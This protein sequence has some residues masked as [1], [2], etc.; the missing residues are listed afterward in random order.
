[1]HLPKVSIGLPV[2]NGEKHLRS[3]LDCILGQDFSDLEVI[4]SDNAS[5]D[6]TQAICQ[7]YAAKDGRIRYLRNEANI[8]ATANYNRVFKLANGEFFKWASHDDEFHGSLVRRCL[9]AYEHSPA[10]TVLVFSKA[11]IIDGGG[12]V[13]CLSHDTIN[14]SARGPF[15]RLASLISHRC[16]AHPLWGLIRSTALQRTRLMGCIEADHVLLAELALQGPFVE[17]PEVLYRERRHAGSAMK[18]HRSAGELLAW[19]DPSRAKVRVLLPHW[20][21]WDIEYWKGIRHAQLS[22]F[23][24]HLCDAVVPSVR[25]WQWLLKVTRPI[26]HRL[27]LRRQQRLLLDEHATT[28][29]E[30]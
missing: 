24:R 27:G 2:Y 6:G 30:G 1:M 3:A 19:H 18:I 11:E 25:L 12:R 5:I 4:I 20:I 8:G 7:E 26:R 17:I 13:L 10:D 29:R 23:E 14:T 9:E 28:A 16:Y 21:R 22:A 15:V